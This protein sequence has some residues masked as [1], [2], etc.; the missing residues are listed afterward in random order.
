[1]NLQYEIGFCQKIVYLVNLSVLFYWSPHR[2]NE[3]YAFRE[4]IPFHTVAT[5]RSVRLGIIT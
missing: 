3:C 1:M 4:P 5:V 2:W